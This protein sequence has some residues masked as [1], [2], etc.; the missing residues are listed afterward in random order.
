MKKIVLAIEGMT[1]SACSNG[2]EKYLNKQEGIK[3]AVVNLVMANALIEYDEKVL[4]QQKIEEFVKKAGFKSLGEFK[5]IKLE[6]NT[7]KEKIKFIIFSFLAI[8]MMYISMGHMLKIPT[9]TFIDMHKSI[10]T[11]LAIL[12]LITVLFLIYGFDILK[13]GYKNLIHK[14]PNMDTLV[15]I[16]VFT[17]FCYSVFN[18]FFIL[19]GKSNYINNLYFESTC[20]IIYFIKLGRIIDG[21]NKNKTKE[22]IQKLVKITPD[23]ANVKNGE[24]ISE[25]TLDEIKIGDILVCKPGEKV[26][27]DGEITYGKT[28]I[29]ESFIT[30]ESKP[31]SKEIN[32]KVIAG[33]INYDGY[34]EYRAQ[35]IGK[36]STVSQIVKYVLEATSSRTKISR[37]ADK[38]SSFFVPSLLIIALIT[39]LV[40]LILGQGIENAITTFI[41]IIVV[42]CPCS[43]GLATPIA[44]VLSEGICVENG[45]LIKKSEIL[46]S[47]KNVDTVVFDKTGT[48]TYGTLKISEI[49]NY[50]KFSE[51]QLLQIIGS[52]E[53]KSSHPIGKAFIEYLNTNK[54]TFLEIKN[55]ENYAGFGISAEVDNEKYIVGN[56]KII[57][58]FNIKNNYKKDEENLSLKQ[59]TIIYIANKQKI[60]AIIGVNDIIKQESKNLINSLNNLKIK[61][62]MITGDNKQVAKNIAQDLNITEVISETLPTEKADIV[63]KLKQNGNFIIMVGDGI[64]D[65]P[66]LANAD[67]GLSIGSGTDI[68]IDS[69]DVVLT[70]NNLNNILKLINISK[71]TIKNIKQ[72]LFWAFF[73][74]VLMIPIAMGVLKPIGISISPMVASIAMVLSSLTVTLNALRIKNIIRRKGI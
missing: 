63:K 13:N 10:N 38:V 54:I 59:N 64:N 8:I 56:S 69:A 7:K 17:S 72:N 30:G 1:C 22:A 15:G 18:T 4:N 9:I 45:I 44:I 31:V 70:N 68:A 29:D 49:H 14:T 51:K 60:L 37:L 6:K 19:K 24:S 58:K 33:S 28:H 39:F 66:A 57:E 61:T 40:Y 27:V 48:L 5:E 50:S 36:D 67:I 32:H 41:T 52:I 11:Y 55:F 53:Q 47:A 74:N 62:I 42:A 34:I 73:Y 12:F 43:L 16:G 65:S 21:I 2:L 20:M 26:A 71:I 25:V 35:K 46:E 23:K 3:N